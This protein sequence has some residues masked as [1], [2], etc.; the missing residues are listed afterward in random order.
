MEWKDYFD[1]EVHYIC[2]NILDCFETAGSL[3][4]DICKVTCSTLWDNKHY[5]ALLAACYL[6][7]QWGDG[8]IDKELEQ[9]P[10][11]GVGRMVRNY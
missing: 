6:V 3:T 10:D 7:I 2:Q 11:W 9:D 1:E 8:V 4:Y 5:I